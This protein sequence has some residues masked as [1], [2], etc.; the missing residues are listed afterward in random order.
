MTVTDVAQRMGRS[1]QYVQ[2]L[3]DRAESSEAEAS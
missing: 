3:R 2:R 1:R